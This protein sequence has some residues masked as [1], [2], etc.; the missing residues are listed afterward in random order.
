MLGNGY[1][2]SLFAIG[3]HLYA[4]LCFGNKAQILLY[5]NLHVV[6]YLV[7]GTRLCLATIWTSLATEE[8]Y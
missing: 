2:L 8:I 4:K 7:V 3:R 6:V 1:I 5:E